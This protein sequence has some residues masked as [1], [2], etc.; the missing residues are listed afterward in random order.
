MYFGAWLLI[1]CEKTPK[2]LPLNAASKAASSG[3]I[4]AI[5]R[6]CTLLSYASSHLFSSSIA[7]LPAND[8]PC[9]PPLG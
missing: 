2:K 8:M 5:L 9:A 6:K 4:I 3:T 1:Y 7:N